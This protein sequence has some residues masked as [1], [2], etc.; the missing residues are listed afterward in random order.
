MDYFTSYGTIRYKSE[1]RVVLD[2]DP[3]ISKYFRKLYSYYTYD[4]EKLSPPS[5]GIHITVVRSEIKIRH[6]NWAGKKINF[7]VYWQPQENGNAIWLPI[8][9]SGLMKFRRKLGLPKIVPLGFHLCIGYRYY[10]RT[11]VPAQMG[12][13]T[14]L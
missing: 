11:E 8:Q 12:V 1:R 14:N 13:L 6:R 4:V 2:C 10:G 5:Q 3:S 9:S 7:R